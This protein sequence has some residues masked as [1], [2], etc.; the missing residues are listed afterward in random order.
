MQF[1]EMASRCVVSLAILSGAVFA[2]DE[3]AVSPARDAGQGVR[4]H[5]VR[6]E[7]QSGTTRIRVL[8][9]DQ[10]RGDELFP[11]VYVLPVEAHE[12]A[13]YGDGLREV[14]QHDL[15][16]KQRAIFVAPTFAQLPWYADHPTDPLVRQ[17]SYFLKVVVPA[18]ERNYPVRAQRDGR[19]LLGF[20]K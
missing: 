18:V 10:R 14:R 17:E 15:H 4:V 7:Y 13:R 5:D 20:S 16:N 1:I 11:V 8:L 3:P 19:L 6:S 9:P 12:E 2:S